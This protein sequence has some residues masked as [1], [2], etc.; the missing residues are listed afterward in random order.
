[1]ARFTDKGKQASRSIKE[2]AQ[3]ICNLPVSTEI[4]KLIDYA[5]TKKCFSLT[6]QNADY[7]HVFYKEISSIRS[8]ADRV[9]RKNQIKDCLELLSDI[10]SLKSLYIP[11][12]GNNIG[13]NEFFGIALFREKA[14]QGFK[15][16]KIS[17]KELTDAHELADN[18]QKIF[19]RIKELGAELE[20]AVNKQQS[21]ISMRR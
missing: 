8:F 7:N 18:A 20:T 6:E 19:T 15:D 17:D 1:M 14:E 3:E 12:T 11:N 16:K 4:G 5:E 2:I 13:E 21:A 9:G 10:Q